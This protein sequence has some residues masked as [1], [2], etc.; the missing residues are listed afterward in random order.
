MRVTY[1][2]THLLIQPF[3]V[4]PSE[5]REWK[6][7]SPGGGGSRVVVAHLEQPASAAAVTA[8]EPISELLKR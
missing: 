4:S 7:V 3:N 1:S 8:E 5:P 6:P 2:V